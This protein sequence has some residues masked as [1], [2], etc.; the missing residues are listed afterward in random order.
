M[1][2]TTTALPDTGAPSRRP[3]GAGPG[4]W[5]IAA[6]FLV[7]MAFSTVPT[8]LYVLYQQRDHFSSFVVTVLFAA[9]AIGVV[10]SL[11]LAG[12]VSDWVGRRKVLVL[13]LLLEA[14]AAVL[15]VV[16]TTVPELF[17]ARLL[18]GVG[19]GMLTATAAAYLSELHRTHRPHAGL[20]RAEL[21][22][23][24][25]NLGG[26]GVGPLV[27]GVLAQYAT[28]PLT[29]SY[30]VFLVLLLVSAAAVGFVPETVAVE[31]R[32]YRPQ[33]VSVPELARA[34]YFAAGAAAF[35]AFATLGLFTSL[36]PAFVA[37]T[38]HLPSRALAGAVAFLV[39]G[40]AASTQILFRRRKTRHQLAIGIATMGV[41]LAVVTLSM[42]VVSLPLFL[43]GGVA[44]GAGIGV[45]FKG[46]VST[47]AALSSPTSRGEALAGLFLAGYVGLVVPVLILGAATQFVATRYALLGF[48]AAVLVISVAAGRRLLKD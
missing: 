46:S 30:A 1:A 43:V 45:L 10:L 2:N 35:A 20:G 32:T 25:A 37:T 24:A 34:H 36:A 31:S 26:L 47:V 13:A 4:F 19:V 29:T 23:T 42:F 22:A 9:Y 6:A 12:H 33:R 16:A 18:T 17:V 7:A 40:A 38:L 8:P 39:F 28:G 5:V 48:S 14:A 41:G 3:V 15:F 44:A 11:F 21:V 27:S